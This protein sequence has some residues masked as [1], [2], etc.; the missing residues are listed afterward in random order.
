MPQK[1]TK[2]P[3]KTK[4]KPAAKP[5]KKAVQKKTQKSILDGSPN[6]P[7]VVTYW[8]VFDGGQYSGIAIPV[9]DTSY[10]PLSATDKTVKSATFD[11]GDDYSFIGSPGNVY[12]QISLASNSTSSRVT[13][14][15]GTL[16]ITLENSAT[17]AN[18]AVD[19]VIDLP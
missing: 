1:K 2:I 7:I 12:L 9:P 4:K 6:L 10:I 13:L 14:G 16:Q 15:L 19:Y 8:D 18:V 5:K 3:A 11:I 17:P